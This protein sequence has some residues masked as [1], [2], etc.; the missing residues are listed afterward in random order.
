MESAAGA[1]STFLA[2]PRAIEIANHWPPSISSKPCSA[3]THPPK[4]KPSQSFCELRE[5]EA[6]CASCSVRAEHGQVLP[7]GDV[8]CEDA[9]LNDREQI[10]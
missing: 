1:P 5:A 8:F 4:S 2:I 7:I 9:W 3:A 6:T 10:G